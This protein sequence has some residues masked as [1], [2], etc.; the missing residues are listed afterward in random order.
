MNNMAGKKIL[1][2]AQFQQMYL[3]DFFSSFLKIDNV[4]ER[5]K[6]LFMMNFC[7]QTPDAFG[8]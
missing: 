1:L 8:V 5:I 3:S 2:H 4:N 7:Q 6:R